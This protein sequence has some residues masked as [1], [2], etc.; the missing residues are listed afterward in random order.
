MKTKLLFTLLI[1]L[2]LGGC[3]RQNAV[4]PPE[5]QLIQKTSKDANQFDFVRESAGRFSDLLSEKPGISR[6]QMFR[7]HWQMN[8]E[9]NEATITTYVAFLKALEKKVPDNLP[10]LEAYLEMKK[11]AEA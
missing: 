8:S 4:V 3:D 2:S 7:A 11:K 10:P 1:T 9:P 5:L 6:R